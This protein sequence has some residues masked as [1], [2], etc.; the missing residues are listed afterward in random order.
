[1]N[2]RQRPSAG[3]GGEGTGRRSASQRAHRVLGRGGR[4][5]FPAGQVQRPQRGRGDR[6]GRWSRAQA[7]AEPVATRRSAG[8]RPVSTDPRRRPPRRRVPTRTAGARPGG[9]VAHRRIATHSPATRA[10]PAGKGRAAGA[11]P[12]ARLHARDALRDPPRADEQH[13]IGQMGGNP[14]KEAVR[15]AAATAR[16]RTSPVRLSVQREIQDVH[17]S[18]STLRERFTPRVLPG[19][20]GRPDLA[21]SGHRL[22]RQAERCGSP[23]RGFTGRRA[24]PRSS[25]VR[26]SRVPPRR[27]APQR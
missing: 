19:L 20:R 13:D 15:A 11:G 22:L 2:A 12:P 26:A 14:R 27:R 17:R 1:M 9:A 10:F 4:G 7:R 21:A 25:G 23:S 18:P 6:D 16:D 5:F 3:L 8:G 24:R